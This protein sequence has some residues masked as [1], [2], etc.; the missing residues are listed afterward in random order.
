MEDNQVPPPFSQPPPVIPPPVTP[1]PVLMRPAPTPPPRRGHGW[2]IFALVL[3]GLLFLSGMMNL[4][5][6]SSG[7]GPV[8]G[9][10]ARVA[11]P[12]LDAALLEDNDAVNKIAVLDINGVIT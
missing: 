11:G 8:K 6:F 12:R 5:L 1:P 10:H 2:M 4:S 7:L 3:L 9:A